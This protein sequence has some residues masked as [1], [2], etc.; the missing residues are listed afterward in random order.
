MLR[1][2]LWRDEAISVSI[3]TAPGLSELLARNRISDY[4]PPLF[5]LLLAGY[6]RIFGTGEVPLKLFALALGQHAVAGATALAWELGGPVAAALTAAF[7]VNNPLLIEM[8]MEVRAYCL[9]AFLTTVCLWVIFRMRRRPPVSGFAA[10]GVLWVLL[11]LLVYS[12]VGGG[13]VNAVLL[14]WGILEWRRNPRLGFGRRLAL[15]ALAAGGSYLFWI[16]TTW[17]QFRV[18]IPWQTPLTPVEK[19]ESLLRRSLEA[20]PIPQAFAQPLFLAAIVLLL[21]AAVFLAP[22]LAARFRGRREALVVPAVAAAAVWLSLGLFSQ[23]SRYLIIPAALGTVVFS[24]ALSRVTEAVSDAPRTQRA[25]VFVALAGL[26]GAAFLAR[27]DFYQGRRAVGVAERPKSGIRTLCRARPFG[28]GEL[29]VVVPDYLAPTV[30]YYCGRSEGLHGFAR[31][32]RPDLFDPG[33]HGA[34]WKDPEA[35]GRLVSRIEAR[36]REGNLER[37]TLVRELAPAGVLPFYAASLAEA[38]AEL[39]RRFESRPAG[40]FPGRIEPVEAFV[41]ERR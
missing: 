14:G 39:A 20:L 40:R 10:F 23:H 35:P 26:I 38:E 8:S 13:V 2:G 36:L 6:A 1:E 32:N 25:A 22:A 16:G 4:N 30:W 21:G 24:V 15:A 9:S 12:H 19:V 18:G 37:Y 31:W 5:N 3:A 41:M 27:R 11:T 17:R 33:D 7:A 28:P 34:R 29:V